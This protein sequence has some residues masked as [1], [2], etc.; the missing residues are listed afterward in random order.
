MYNL[1][2]AI[3]SLKREKN[4]VFQMNASSHSQHWVVREKQLKT[5][6]HNIMQVLKSFGGT[7]ANTTI[8]F[9]RLK[10]VW[11]LRVFQSSFEY[12]KKKIKTLLTSGPLKFLVS[13]HIIFEIWFIT[14]NC[15][16]FFPHKCTFDPYISILPLLVPKIKNTFHF[17]PYCHPLNRNILHGKQSALLA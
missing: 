14:I 6:I 11:L 9:L 13:S 8:V 17:G 1:Y 15:H 4:Q 7:L 3:N 16:F 5:L 10:S 2:P 12:Y